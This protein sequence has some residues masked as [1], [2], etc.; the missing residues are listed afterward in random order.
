MRIERSERSYGKKKGRGARAAMK[1]ASTKLL[2]GRSSLKYII[3]PNAR[4]VS[5]TYEKCTL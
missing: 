1:I 4:Q 5:I 3:M 2:G